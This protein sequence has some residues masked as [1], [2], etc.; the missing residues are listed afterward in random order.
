[1]EERQEGRAQASPF[2]ET[3]SSSFG[4]SEV[5]YSGLQDMTFGLCRLEGDLGFYFMA[6]LSELQLAA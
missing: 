2:L 5:Q 4:L 6:G 3:R 1:M